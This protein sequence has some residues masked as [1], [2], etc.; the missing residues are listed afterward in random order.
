MKI[1]L[2]IGGEK[3]KEKKENKE[4]NE[5]SE[6][7]IKEVNKNTNNKENKDKKENGDNEG[8]D[9]IYDEEN[10]FMRTHKE[11]QPSIND[12]FKEYKVS[13]PNSNSQPC[14]TDKNKI[15]WRGQWDNDNPK[16]ENA[17]SGSISLLNHQL[18]LQKFFNLM[19]DTNYR[20]LLLYHGLG[21]GKTCSAIA[22]SIDSLK[23]KQVVFLSPASLK[24]N[25][26]LELKKCG[27]KEYLIPKSLKK[28]Q[29]IDYN[30]KIDREIE[31]KFFFISYNASN[32]DQKI[33]EIPDKLNNK[34]LIIDEVHNLISM[35]FNQ[36]KKGLY[37]YETIMNAKDLKIIFL[38][39]TPIINDPGEIA[40]LFNLLAG[41][42]YPDNSIF[43]N[44]GESI[45][46]PP[47]YFGTKKRQ[48]KVLFDLDS[49]YTNFIDTKDPLKVRV[50]NKL[51]FKRRIQGLVSYFR[52]EQPEEN[53][54]PNKTEY[55][56]Y[57][58]MSH[59]QFELYEAARKIERELENS[60]KNS[61]VKKSS[62]FGK[63]SFDLITGHG[64]SGKNSSPSLFRTFSRQ[65]CNFAFPSDIPRPLPKRASLTVNKIDIK[66]ED[67]KLEDVN[68]SQEI[69]DDFGKMNINDKKRLEYAINDIAEKKLT[70]LHKDKQLGVHSQ[71]FLKMIQHIFNSPGTCF[72]YSQFYQ[73]EGIG[74]F[75]LT[76]QAHGYIEYGYND[77]EFNQEHVMKPVD[78]TI[79]SVSGKRWD[80]CSNKEKQQFVPLT[81]IKW[82]DIRDTHGRHVINVFNNDEN[83]YGKFIKVFLATKSGAEGISLMNIRQVHLM[84]PYWHDVLTE[85]AMGRA[86]RRCSHV[87]LPPEERNVAVFRYISTHHKYHNKDK[88]EN[89]MSISTDESI[90]RIA[91]RKA[92]INDAIKTAMKEVSI[93]CKLNYS[94]NNYGESDDEKLTCFN[95]DLDGL[96]Y[97]KI[98]RVNI[99]EEISDKAY[100]AR[101]RTENKKLFKLK[102]NYRIEE[103][104][105]YLITF[106][107]K[108]QFDKLEGKVIYFYHPHIDEIAYRYTIKNGKVIKKEY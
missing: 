37:F 20:G 6:N 106:L 54:L 5:K 94:H 27:P 13:E 49:F 38:S 23:E 69:V 26:I 81:Y 97:D 33:E 95:V 56:E 39:G 14:L 58:E 103:K 31:K 59:H 68:N 7:E 82:T 77:P 75:A 10:K 91:L 108:K 67:I 47:Y 45:K 3:K 18:F 12:K 93:D 88:D 71:K 30:K 43:E 101:Y 98:Y 25:F 34:I 1:K 4:K 62:K 51:M 73:A 104:D 85:Q 44:K 72:V 79:D 21:S 19:I 78:Y 32:A 9:Q 41:Y 83:K 35:I 89:N 99:D 87:S 29:I 107:A 46:N 80:K 66:E 63:K 36:G 53:I 96:D 102:N 11:F 40:I 90:Y 50:K 76:L 17:K 57:L 28:E 74:L 15:K 16:V 22:M 86:I 64:S 70:Y 105:I 60:G 2:K 65:L 92:T 24:E 84:E 42:I 100:E 55:V 52:G 48:K 8:N 61:Y